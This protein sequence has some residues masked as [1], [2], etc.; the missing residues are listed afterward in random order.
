VRLGGEIYDGVDLVLGEEARNKLGVTDVAVCEN[1]SR[2]FR[3]IGEIGRV[4]SVGEGVE[5]DEFLERRAGLGE[6][7]ANEIGANETATAC[8]E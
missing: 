8:N 3:Q 5:V 4:A 6:S 7:L 2:I 1:V